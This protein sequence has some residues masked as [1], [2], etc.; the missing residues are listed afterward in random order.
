MGGTESGGLMTGMIDKRSS[1]AESPHFQRAAENFACLMNHVAA[2]YCA[3][4]SSSVSA[5]EAHELSLSVTYALGIT[6]ATPEE[7]TRVLNVEDPIALWHDAL[8]SLDKR[9]DDA[10][11]LLREVIVTM[12]PIRNISLRDTLASLSEL[13]T[14]YDTRFAAHIVPCDIDYQLSEPVDSSLL[15][16]D[17]VTAWLTQ[18]LSEARWI[19]QFT[20]TSCEAALER[21]YPDYRG[22][23]VNLYDLLRPH[24][25]ELVLLK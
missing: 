2:L 19:A 12:P 5:S 15:G 21:A 13:R 20:A 14:R 25:E 16:I 24:E 3:G 9:T 22:L 10:L 11:V 4:D 18:L 17:Y 7:A 6:H 23:H 1:D 8:S